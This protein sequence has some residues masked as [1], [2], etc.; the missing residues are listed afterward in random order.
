MQWPERTDSSFSSVRTVE[1]NH[2]GAT[3][4]T[5]GLILNFGAIN[6]AD[7]GEQVDE[8]LVAGRPGQLYPDESPILLTKSGFNLRCARR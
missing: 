3:G 2:T 6:L 7:G 4:A 5:I 1:L 8:V